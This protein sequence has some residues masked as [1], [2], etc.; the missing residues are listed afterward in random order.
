MQIARL[1]HMNNDTFNCA[2]LLVWRLVNLPFVTVIVE[3]LSLVSDF[4]TEIVELVSLVGDAVT[5][6]VELVSLVATVVTAFVHLL[7]VVNMAALVE[8]SKSLPVD[9]FD[10]S[11]DVIL[12]VS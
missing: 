10:V 11:A 2:A 8:V 5:A 3:L 12:T 7:L 9:A 6:F 1:R 4:M